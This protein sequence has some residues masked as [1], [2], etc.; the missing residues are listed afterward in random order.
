MSTADLHEEVAR[1][2][3]AIVIDPARPLI[4]SDADE[5]LASFMQAFEGF[6]ARQ[7]LYFNWQSYRLNGNVRRSGDDGEVEPDG[8]RALLHD[9]FV[10][11]TGS[12]EPVTGAAEALAVLS[13][14]AQIIVLSNVPFA[15]TEARRRWLERHD[16]AYPLIA[17]IGPK[18]PA[19]C[20]LA[21]R[22]DAPVYFIDDSPPHHA[23]VARAAERVRRLHFVADAR[24]AR[25]L[26]PAP[27]S[28]H[29]ADSWPEMRAFIE[30]DLAEQGY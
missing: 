23:A 11:C 8:V 21:K 16:L 25:L 26:G 2:I 12:I 5:V 29:R 24:L 14:R 6:L 17:N 13:R 22:T 19:M 7:E 18:G 20:D 9:F 10:E 3:E 27:D 15:Q 4:V 30:A 28:H 1:Q